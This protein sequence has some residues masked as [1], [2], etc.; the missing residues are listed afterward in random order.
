MYQMRRVQNGKKKPEKN[1]EKEHKNLGDR[2]L[3]SID[4]LSWGS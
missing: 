4:V 1:P 2:D 3:F